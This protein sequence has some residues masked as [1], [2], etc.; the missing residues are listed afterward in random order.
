MQLKTTSR[1]M[2]R[3][4]ERQKSRKNAPLT[5]AVLKHKNISRNFKTTRTKV[6]KIST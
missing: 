4:T 5:K 6:V 2:L 3:L 1:K